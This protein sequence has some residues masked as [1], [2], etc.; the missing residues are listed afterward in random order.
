MFKIVTLA[1]G[2]ALLVPGPASADI[3]T[4]CDLKRQEL[5]P[6]FK[7]A[8]DYRKYWI[9]LSSEVFNRQRGDIEACKKLPR[10]I[11]NRCL[12]SRDTTLPHTPEM[13]AKAQKQEYSIKVLT[14]EA[15]LYSAY[16][17][18]F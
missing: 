3:K 7:D 2:L 14:E 1:L 9:Q 12:S 4:F 18:K 10:E 15:P 5:A 8:A 11:K 13:V 16:C 17:K 6:F